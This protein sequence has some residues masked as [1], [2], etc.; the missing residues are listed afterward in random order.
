MNEEGVCVHVRERG[1]VRVGAGN[2]VVFKGVLFI[3]CQLGPSQQEYWR[4]NEE[5]LKGA[6]K[7]FILVCLVV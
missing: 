6:G 7:C 2:W 3:G 4:P 5:A 1:G